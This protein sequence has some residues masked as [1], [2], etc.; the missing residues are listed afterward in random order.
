MSNFLPSVDNLSSNVK[1]VYNMFI[2]PVF[3]HRIDEQDDDYLE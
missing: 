1:D 3:G 2:V